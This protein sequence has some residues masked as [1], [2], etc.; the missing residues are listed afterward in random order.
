MNDAN[1]D[2]PHGNRRPQVVFIVSQPRAGSTLLQTMLGG[3]PQV[4]APGETWLM[5]PLV[6]AIHGSTRAVSCP[7]D[8]YLADHAI[9]LFAQNYLA[10][11]VGDI[12]RELGAAAARIFA[13]VCARANT[14]VVIDK[15]PRYYWIIDDLLRLLP[16]CHVIV[17]L[18]NP[19][20]VLSSMVKTWSLRSLT[21]YRADLLEAPSRLANATEYDSRRITTVRYEQLVESPDSVLME[22]QA[23]I[24]LDPVDGLSEYGLAPRRPFGDPAGI[25]QS[26]SANRS[27]LEKWIQDASRDASMWRLLDDYRRL[28]G[29]D[30]TMRLGYNFEQLEHTLRSVKP[31][32]TSIA[33]SLTS[34]L[35]PRPVE[36]VRSFRRFR[37]VCA[38]IASSATRQAA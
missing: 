34:Q 9:S 19:L 28:L 33:P 25:H 36:P 32:G 24:G 15:T 1:R 12:Q 21:N 27:S 17:L 26:T 37:G 3:H 10:R 7:Y 5:L 35:G 11:G 8:G 13:S 2:E 30:L 23:R 20:A 4:T 14:Q 16:D 31:F 6:H 18:R 29:R 22:L 38:R